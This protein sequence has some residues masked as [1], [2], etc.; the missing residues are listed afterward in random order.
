MTW[1]PE[2][3]RGVSLGTVRETFRTFRPALRGQSLGL[4]S[5]FLLTLLVTGLELLRP[6]PIKFIFDRVLIPQTGQPGAF[7]LSPQGTLV[8][9]AGATLLISVLL[10]TLVQRSTIVAAQVGRKATVR[11]RR[12][13]FEHLHKLAFPFHHTSRTGDLLVR[14]MG[15]VNMIRDALFASWVN[16]VGRGTLFLG[17]AVIMFLL[18]PW[19]ALL[20]LYPLPL[21]G[22]ELGRSSRKLSEVARKQRRREGDA[23]SFAA[24]SLRQIRV[25]KAY[26]AE[27]RATRMFSKDSRSGERAGVQGARITAHMERMT[28]ILTGAGLAMVLFVGASWTVSGRLTAGELLVFVSYARS[29]YKPLRKVSNEGTRL[30]KATACAGRV[31]E[32]LRMSPE[33]FGVGRP[34]PEFRGALALEDVHYRYADGNEAL[35]GIT[36]AFEP[37]D[38]VVVSGP[39]GSGK[40]TL[41]SVLLR[42]LVP[43][44]G[45]VLLDDEPIEGFELE[46]YRN[47]FAYV[48][49]DTQLFGATIRENILYGRPDAAE[50]EIRAAARAALFD[51]VAA[52]LPGG[53][54]AVLGEDGATLSGGEARRLMLAR[55][56]LRHARVLL[57]DEPLSG[58][59]PEARR[60]V[61]LAIRRIAAGRTTIVVSHGPASELDP[62]LI[63]RMAEG[64]VRSVEA[65]SRA[66]DDIPEAPQTV[67]RLDQRRVIS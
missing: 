43:T 47:R 53:Y 54:D 16:I 61:G 65:V 15:D 25:V 20:A 45:R 42:L 31:L 66:T 11:I 1:V 55:A 21:L 64:R 38:L 67:I 40:S 32:V 60:L 49:Q 33:S 48:P 58:L 14:L 35:R 10:G 62:D 30:S 56:A 52:R 19:L 18:E 13:V 57:L 51:G 12:Q 23:A 4:A 3:F 6:W 39:N 44:S 8:A 9:A 22:L 5:S 36:V 24:E 37:G 7:G 2:S 50:A 41:L 59:D 63:L 28:E 34:A 17:T 26:A 46:S 27:D 29:L